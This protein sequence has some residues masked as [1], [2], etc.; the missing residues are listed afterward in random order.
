M[1]E[2][3]PEFSGGKMQYK[4]VGWEGAIEDLTRRCIP[5]L[6]QKAF[7]NAM[8]SDN[9]MVAL[10]TFKEF[11]DRSFGKA[12]ETIKIDSGS[13]K[14]AIKAVRGLIRDGVFTR[15]Q[16]EAQLKELGIIDVE[17][18]EDSSTG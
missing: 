16:G 1:L 10:A 9:P 11:S 14:E 17:F 18:E 4:G 2:M 5:A 8:T 15:K 12:K 7:D 3:L 6:A 13:D